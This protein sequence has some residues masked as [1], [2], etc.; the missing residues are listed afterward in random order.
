MNLD[1]AQQVLEKNIQISNFMEIRPAGA[2]LFRADGRTRR[3]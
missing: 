3:S 2:Q 1:F